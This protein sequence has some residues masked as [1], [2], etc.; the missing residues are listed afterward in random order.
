[1]TDKKII[2]IVGPSGSG[3]TSIGK[4]LTANG[5]PRLK[6]T[7]TRAMRPGEKDGVDYYFRDLDEMN[8]EDFVEQTVYNKNLYGLTK[9]EVA[10]MLNQHD[11]VHVSLD[12]NGAQSVKRAF[13]EETFIVFVLVSEDEMIERMRQRGDAWENIRARIQFSRDTNE[14]VPPEGTDLV[15][16]NVDVEKTAHQ[17]IEAVQTAAHPIKKNK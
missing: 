7:T 16:K 1:M 6:T 2:V 3:K 12:K 14:R 5:I 15:V 10:T 8:A 13:P 11:M 4:I 9:H 17:I